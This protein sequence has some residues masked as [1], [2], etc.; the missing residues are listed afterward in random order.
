VQGSRTFGSWVWWPCICVAACSPCSPEPAPRKTPVIEQAVIE[1]EKPRRAPDIRVE[2]FA[3][4]ESALH[5][6]ATDT[7]LVSNV[8]GSPLDADDNGF[9]SRVT[10]DGKVAALKWIDGAREDVTLNAPK[11]MAIGNGVL[12][13]ADITAVRRFDATSGAPLGEVIIRGA[14]FLNDVAV[15]GGEVVVSD[16]GAQLGAKGLEPT[17]SDAIYRIRGDEVTT[18]IKSTELGQPNGL[19][20][21]ESGIWVVSFGSG[22]LYRLVDGTRQDVNKLPFGPL[23]GVVRVA[24]GELLIASWGKSTV[25]K[26]KENRELVPELEAVDSPADLGYDAKRNRALV[27]LFQQNVLVIHPLGL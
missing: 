25:F 24:D 7:Y 26:G 4:P 23:D 21:E 27:P 13:V 19:W 20:Y 10:P 8:N 11:G 16:T 12:Y 15:S 14:T 17:G 5:D 3:T 6:P 9:I 2:G 18:L 22:E 1:P